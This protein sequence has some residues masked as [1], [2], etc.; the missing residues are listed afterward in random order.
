MSDNIPIPVDYD[1]STLT[2][3]KAKEIIDFHMLYNNKVIGIRGNH[4]ITLK[5][6]CYSLYL[7][8]NNK[9]YS[10]LTQDEFKSQPGIL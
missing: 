8:Y 10:N 7:N 5:N 9:I 2:I 4:E 6:G 1:I 3:K